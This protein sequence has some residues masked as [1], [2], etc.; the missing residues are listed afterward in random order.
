MIQHTL[1]KESKM[2]LVTRIP[3]RL[4]GL[5]CMFRLRQH[6]PVY[7]GQDCVNKI[8][9]LFILFMVVRNEQSLDIISIRDL[10]NYYKDAAYPFIVL[11]I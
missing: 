5:S 2:D 7:I 4:N 11:N 8:T 1:S 3:K 10:D 6:S 9:P